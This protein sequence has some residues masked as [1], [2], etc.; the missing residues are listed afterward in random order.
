MLSNLAAEDSRLSGILELGG[1]LLEGR[2]GDPPPSL[3][4]ADWNIGGIM[5][6]TMGK[7]IEKPLE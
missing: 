6:K 1:D 7:T 3:V 4:G 2:D 5:T